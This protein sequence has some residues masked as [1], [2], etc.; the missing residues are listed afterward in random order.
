MGTD[1]TII[2]AVV[3]LAIAAELSQKRKNIFVLEQNE[4]FGIKLLFK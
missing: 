4:R 3:G 1:T 2:V